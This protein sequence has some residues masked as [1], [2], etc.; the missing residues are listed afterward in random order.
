MAVRAMTSDAQRLLDKIKEQIDE[1]HIDTWAYD[2]AGDFTHTP[3]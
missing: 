1:G 2:G 3:D